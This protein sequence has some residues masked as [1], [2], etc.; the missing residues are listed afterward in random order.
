MH[1]SDGNDAYFYILP[2]IYFLLICDDFRHGAE[3]V[4]RS[5][6]AVHQRAPAFVGTGYRLGD[7]E[8]APPVAVAGGASAMAPRQVGLLFYHYPN[9]LFK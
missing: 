4:E 3:V 6:P 1:S 9:E 2:P 8:D 7:T 5:E